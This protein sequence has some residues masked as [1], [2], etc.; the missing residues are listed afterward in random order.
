M[1]VIGNLDG[2]VQIGQGLWHRLADCTAIPQ[3]DF[4][5]S[6]RMIPP[7]ESFDPSPL[8]FWVPETIPEWK[9]VSFHITEFPFF[10]FLF[11]DLHAHMMVI[12]L[13]LLVIGLGVNL[14]MGLSREGPRWG[15]LALVAVAVALGSLWAVNSWDYP[16]YALL[17]LALLGLAVYRSDGSLAGKALVFVAVS[18]GVV[19]VSL[20]AFL[21]FHQNYET[22][23]NGLD[24]L[25]VDDA[26]RP[27]PGYPC[28]VPVHWR[29]L[30]ADRRQ[31]RLA[32]GSRWIVGPELMGIVGT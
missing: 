11:A 18:V 15:L 6:S 2:A 12:P 7:L 10:T 17:V 32:F 3:F 25:H 22:F 29:D 28:R 16:S 27:V 20:L 23:N 21:P 13:T 26:G 4:W 31:G 30:P 19:A 9:D 5:R 24:P 14:V 8:A 1:L